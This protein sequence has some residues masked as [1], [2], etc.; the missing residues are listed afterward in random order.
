M[1]KLSFWARD[2]KSIARAIIIISLFFITLL[3]FLVGKLLT[4]LDISLDSAYITGFAAVYFLAF[5][6]YPDQKRKNYYRQKTMDWLLAFSTFGMVI[7]GANRPHELFNAKFSVHAA[8]PFSTEPTD[9]L[10]RSYKTIKEFSASLKNKDGSSLKWKQKKQ[11]LKQQVSAIKH[12]K[13]LSQGGKIALIILSVLVAVGLLALLA[14]LACNI[15]CSG[16]E[17]LAI[18]VGLVGAGLIIFLLIVV[19][20][21]INRKYRKARKESEKEPEKPGL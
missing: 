17:G 11:L 7:Y 19:I 14:A 8:I 2:H 10:K 12:A 21:A 6:L 15:S 16:A 1:R 18:A 5:F 13:D 3:G 20:R 4:S 9:S